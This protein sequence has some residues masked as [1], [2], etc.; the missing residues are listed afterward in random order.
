MILYRFQK[1]GGVCDSISCI[2]DVPFRI[3]EFELKRFESGCFQL[4]R[5]AVLAQ[6]GQT[7]VFCFDAFDLFLIFRR[8]R[9]QFRD[10]IRFQ[11]FNAA[12]DVPHGFQF[13]VECPACL[14]HLL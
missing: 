9:F 3:R 6:G 14:M 5:F 4:E 1:A 2:L 10:L 11:K 13:G 12:G 7:V 8:K